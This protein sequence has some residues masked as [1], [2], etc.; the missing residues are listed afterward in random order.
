MPAVQMNKETHVIWAVYSSDN[1][2]VIRYSFKFFLSVTENCEQSVQDY[3]K[4]LNNTFQ[5]FL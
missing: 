4:D 5:C 3:F 1:I 2:F